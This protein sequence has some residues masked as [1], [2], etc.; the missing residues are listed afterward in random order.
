M[1]SKMI[2]V[3]VLAIG[4][5]VNVAMSAEGLQKKDQVKDR[6]Q[7]FSPTL[8]KDQTRLQESMP[9]ELKTS[10]QDMT[11]A[12]DK[13]QQQLRDQQKDV[14]VC[15]DAKRDQ[16]RDQLKD[17]IKDQAKDREQIRERL[18]ELRQNLPTHQELMDQAR[19]KA[20]AGG[21]G[22]TRRGE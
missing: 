9:A 22:T 20:G 2:I 12:R 8:Q 10:V 13:Y 17:Q 21:S 14:A 5:G 19:E 3:T 18:Q 15:T 7:T 11:Q 4:C 1:K 6:L 16:L